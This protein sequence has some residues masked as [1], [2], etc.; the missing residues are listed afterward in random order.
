MTDLT[1][2]D[3]LQPGQSALITKVHGRNPLRQR[4]LDM[5][6]VKDTHIEVVGF[7]PLGDP[8]QISVRGYRLAIRKREA[9]LIEVRPLGQARTTNAMHTYDLALPAL[10]LHSCEQ[11]DTT[12]VDAPYTI[13][14]A[15]NPNCGKSTLFNGLTGSHQ[16][17]G[18]WPGKTVEKKEGLWLENGSRFRVVDLPGIYSL[19]AYSLEEIIA[20]DAI[21][22]SKANLVVVVVDAA[23]LER[24]LYLLV[25]I[26]EMGVPALLVLNM[27]DMALADGIRINLE[28]LSARLGI[29]VIPTTL[30]RGLG[31]AE[32]KQGLLE[33]L[34]PA[35]ECAC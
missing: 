3:R 29:P 27:W 26:L 2:L 25:Q 31:L 32:L 23:N 10:Q 35:G 18:N 33:L 19:T 15:G 21:L 17:V 14:L 28:E 12:P 9:A 1:F 11:G 5:G 8:I 4:F 20:R 6:L 16:H 7:A 13:L 24:N 22:G 34:T 30:S